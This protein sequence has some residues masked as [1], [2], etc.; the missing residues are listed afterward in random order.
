MQSV[1][2]VCL[3]PRALE[4][5]PIL[6]YTRNYIPAE[7][8]TRVSVN[9]TALSWPADRTMRPPATLAL[10]G[11]QRR[12]SLFFLSLSL[13]PGSTHFPFHRARQR[14]AQWFFMKRER[15]RE[16]EREGEE[17]RKGICWRPRARTSLTT[18]WKRKSRKKWGTK[19][20]F[21]T[22][23]LSSRVLVQKGRGWGGKGDLSFI[24]TWLRLSG[25]EVLAPTKRSSLLLLLYIPAVVC[26]TRRVGWL[27]T[28]PIPS[29]GAEAANVLKYRNSFS[30]SLL[31]S[32]R[33]ITLARD[34]VRL[35]CGVGMRWTRG[36]G[37]RV[38]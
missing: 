38:D 30:P 6:P 15:E 18:N 3:P 1:P 27:Y 16:R 23:L 10:S 7:R 21:Y 35:E 5:T 33:A 12:S 22:V 25:R 13:F 14:V 31:I 2:E 36:C 32:R 28:L 11:R 26:T 29:A 34:V 19:S 24:I 37:M 8:E 9:N 4:E 20:I 17:G